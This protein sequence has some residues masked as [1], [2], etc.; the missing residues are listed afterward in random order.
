MES[1]RNVVKRGVDLERRCCRAGADLSAN[2]VFGQ[3]SDAAGPLSLRQSCES[4]FY[5]SEERTHSLPL[6]PAYTAFV[7]VPKVSRSYSIVHG[8]ESG[9][10]GRILGARTCPCTTCNVEVAHSSRG[11]QLLR[12]LLQ[13]FYSGLRGLDGVLG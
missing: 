3:R 13:G 12:T 4:A 7:S 11:S 6:M 2:T 5:S 9:V 1:N 10:A 8:R